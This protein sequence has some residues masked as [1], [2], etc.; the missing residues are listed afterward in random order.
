MVDSLYEVA[1]GSDVKRREA[2]AVDAAAAVA[3]VAV[4]VVT[5]ADSEAETFSLEQQSV[6]ILLNTNSKKG[7]SSS[8]DNS[9]ATSITDIQ[10]QRIID[11]ESALQAER[12]AHLQMTQQYWHLKNETERDAFERATQS[13][14]STPRVVETPRNVSN[15][16]EKEDLQQQLQQA[17]AES[18]H[19]RSE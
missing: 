6:F 18:Q 12:D 7:I 16:E 8:P 15:N 5:P 11:L 9:A 13:V 3:A 1:G 4:Q 19:F 10:S 14:P 2:A 17:R